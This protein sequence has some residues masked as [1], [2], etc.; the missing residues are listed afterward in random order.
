MGMTEVSLEEIVLGEISAE[1]WC[2]SV[3]MCHESYVEE[4]LRVPFLDQIA[5]VNGMDTTWE[6]GVNTKFL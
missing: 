2:F 4:D 1:E 5:E 3:N 6:A